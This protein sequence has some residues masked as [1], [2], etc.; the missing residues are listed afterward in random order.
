MADLDVYKKQKFGQKIG[1]GKKSALLIIDFQVGF[2][3]A[4]VLGGFNMLSA[5]EQTS[6]LLKIARSSKVPVAH[7]RFATEMQG[8]DIGTFAVKVPTLKK[9]S[10]DSKDAQFVESVRPKKGEWVSTKRHG[11]AFFGT[12]LAAWLTFVGVDTLFITGCTTSGCV[13]ASTI[14]AS[15]YGLRP[16]VVTDCVGD[17]AEGPHRANLFDMEQKYADLVTSKQVVAYFKALKNQ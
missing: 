8:D 14:D 3:D 6:K 10:P 11:S 17:R 1:F 7:V 15:A 9:L 5:I 13:R 16:M 2:A 4:D 12:N